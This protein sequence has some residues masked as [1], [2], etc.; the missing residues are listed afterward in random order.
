M[1]AFSFTSSGQNATAIKLL[2]RYQLN[3]GN[4]SVKPKVIIRSTVNGRKIE[5]AMGIRSSLNSKTAL[6]EA[7][8]AST[9]A[10]LVRSPLHNL[11]MN[12]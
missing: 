6:I 10:A 2:V 8:R 3:S 12:S 7:K 4:E 11:I 5:C 1:I 9:S